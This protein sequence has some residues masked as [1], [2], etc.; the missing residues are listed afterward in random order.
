[1]TYHVH[2]DERMCEG[3]GNCIVAAPHI[4][5]LDPD[6]NIAAVLTGRTTDADG[7]ALTEAGSDCPVRAISFR[8][9]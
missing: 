3:H 7:P 2:V 6:T 1:M 5:A 8:R 4:F 9:T